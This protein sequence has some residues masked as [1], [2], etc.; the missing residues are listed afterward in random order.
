MKL[1]KGGGH[2]P[3]VP[4]GVSSAHSLKSRR[5]SPM[6]D[7][8]RGLDEIPKKSPR[9]RDDEY[10]MPQHFVESDQPDGTANGPARSVFRTPRGH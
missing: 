8:V 2:S 4:R 1:Q 10:E 9:S 5:A 3:E 6:C 7:V